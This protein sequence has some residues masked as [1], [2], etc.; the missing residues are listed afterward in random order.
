MYWTSIEETWSVHSMRSMWPL[1]M[2]DFRERTRQYSYMLMLLAALFMSYLILTD[3]YSFKFGSFQCAYDAVWVGTILASA[4]TAMLSIFGFYLVKNSIGRDR[5]TGVGQILAATPLSRTGYLFSKF[6]SNILVLWSMIGVLAVAGM[7][8]LLFRGEPGSFQFVRFWTP[9]ILIPVPAM[10]MVA[11]LAVFFESTR[12]LRGGMGNVVY[13]FVA[14]FMLISGVLELTIFDLASMGSFS[15]S[16]K[17]AIWH[18]YPGIKIDM[19]IGFIKAMKSDGATTIQP[20]AWQGIH[21]SD[22]EIMLRVLWILIPVV[23]VGIG[24]PLF[25]RF[26]PSRSRIKSTSSKT[27]EKAHKIV[28]PSGPASITLVYKQIAK[29]IPDYGLVSMI[30]AEWRVA[31]KQFHLVWYGLAF[32]ILAAQLVAPINIVRLWVIPIAMIWPLVV[33]S[34]MGNRD[35]RHGTELL[36]NSSPRPMVRQFVATW[37]SGCGVALVLLSGGMVRAIISAD[38]PYLAALVVASLIIPSAGIVI[39]TVSG[40]RKLFEVSYLMVWYLG[41]IEHLTPIDIL[42]TTD[43]SI[44]AAKLSLLLLLTGLSLLVAWMVRIR[45][46]RS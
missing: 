38:L 43:A 45:Q 13:Y 19:A 27:K 2:A 14:Q 1:I 31:F 17:E 36:L 9:I 35:R 5:K 25:D 44:T 46:L 30:F 22:Y 6:A 34:S 4:S 8:T 23:L 26:D 3:R 16:I 28:R 15:R 40:S 20:F 18:V 41:S 7:I 21:W 39:G 11:G 24:V 33:W 12:W 42:G 37:M 29:V 10:V 32:L